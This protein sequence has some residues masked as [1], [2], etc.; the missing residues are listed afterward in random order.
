MLTVDDLFIKDGYVLDF[1]NA[2]FATFFRE[3]IGVDIDDLKWSVEGTSKGKRLRFF[4]RTVGLPLALKT[5]KALWEH[6]QVQLNRSGM[7]ETVANAKGRFDELRARLGDKPEPTKE[8]AFSGPDYSKVKYDVIHQALVSLTD[9]PPQERGYKFEKFLLKMFN[10]FGL[11]P[12]KAFRVTG[13]QIDGSFLLYG[14]TYLLEAKWQN[15]KTGVADLHSFHGKVDNRAAW[16][17]GLFVSYSGFT[18]DG[19]IAFG[20]ARKVICMDGLDISDALLR[21]IPL[22]EVL[23][24]KA[25]KAVEHGIV[26]ARVSDLFR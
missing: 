24:A 15:E 23:H 25:R 14:E 4:L 13:E 9:R 26:H 12:E 18:E 10:A 17:R 1:S 20:R 6:R 2:R 21:K 19:L 11:E 22:P 3:E 8:A 7:A 5:L 16:A